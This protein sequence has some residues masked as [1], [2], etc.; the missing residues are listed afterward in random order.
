MNNAIRTKPYQVLFYRGISGFCIC[1]VM[2]DIDVPLNAQT[3]KT[4]LRS[5]NPELSENIVVCA[6]SEIKD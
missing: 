6:W 2:H 3:I 5:S 1:T 4:E